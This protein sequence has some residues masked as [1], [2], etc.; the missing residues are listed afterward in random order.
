MV[1]LT[2]YIFWKFHHL[3]NLKFYMAVFTI[4]LPWQ[5]LRKA[6]S[7]REEDPSFPTVMQVP[8]PAGWAETE[9][10]VNSPGRDSLAHDSCLSEEIQVAL[11]QLFKQ[12]NLKFHLPLPL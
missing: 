10:S 6:R 5:G 4:V 12:I 7:A 2:R 8:Q 9:G 3:K 1:I 11:P